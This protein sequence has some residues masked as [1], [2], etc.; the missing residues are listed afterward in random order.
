MLILTSIKSHP[1]KVMD[2][3]I[4]L[5]QYNCDELANLAKDPEYGLYDEAL[6]IYKKFN[7]PVEAIRVII[8][9]LNN[10]KQA[11]EYA[12]KINQP[13][14]FSELGKAQLD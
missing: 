10:I 14:V 4:K 7:K 1:N 9:N 5:D 3:I 11:S 6:A 12:D 8:Y 2:Y 13:E